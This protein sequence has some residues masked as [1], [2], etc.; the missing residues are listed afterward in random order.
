MFL[1]YLIILI[2]IATCILLGRIIFRRL[3][4]LK[5]LDIKAIPKEKQGST[6]IKILEAKFMRQKDETGAK[7]DKVAKPLKERFS[8]WTGGLKE[9]VAVLENK[10]KRHEA[11]EVTK[12]K[13]DSELLSEAKAFLEADKYA[14]AEKSLIEILSRDKKNI[15]AYELLAKIYRQNKSY[16]Q[17][18]EIMRYLIKL[19]TL[20]YRKNK[21]ADTLKKDKM[22]ESDMALIENI[23]VDNEIARY[24]DDLAKIYELM[25]KKDKALDSYLKASTIEP[26]NPRLLDRVIDLSIALGDRGL[27]K[28][29]YK[30]LKEINPENGKL[31]KFLEALEKLK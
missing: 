31:D 27:A 12:I 5:V 10:Y 9:K 2:I 11:V 26:N 8:S 17:A 1:T 20:K 22:D 4:D 24:Y 7:L 13:T 3:P 25:D 18:E 21:N 28:K 6:K 30:R 19:K 29:T 14:E 16:E 23:D 15:A